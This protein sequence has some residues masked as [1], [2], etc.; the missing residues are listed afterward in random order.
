[1][2]FRLAKGADLTALN[3]L[4]QQLFDGDKISPRQM[5]RF[6]HS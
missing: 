5:K 3:A 6:L 2:D 1:M 4:E